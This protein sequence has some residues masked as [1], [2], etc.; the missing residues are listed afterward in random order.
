LR[1]LFKDCWEQSKNGK[2]FLKAKGY[3]VAQGDKRGAV[4]VDYQ[5]EVYALSRWIGV[6][7][8]ELMGRLADQKTFLSVDEAKHQIVPTVKRWFGSYLKF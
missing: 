6:K 7:S 2:A 4:A 1:A 3:T 8:K 5:G